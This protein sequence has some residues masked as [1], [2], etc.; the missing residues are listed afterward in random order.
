[1]ESAYPLEGPT[2][3]V[4]G[5]MGY[6]LNPVFRRK[7]DELLESG[8]KELLLDLSQGLY[9]SSSHIGV[10]ADLAVRAIESDRK[11][12]VRAVGKVARVLKFAGLEQI[13][14]LEVVD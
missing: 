11:V 3:R 13:T 6:D 4:V 8:E 10:I 5:A 1:M 14:D 12:K 2:L 7:C 9:L